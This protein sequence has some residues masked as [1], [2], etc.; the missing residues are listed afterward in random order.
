MGK[1]SFGTARV[2]SAVPTSKSRASSPSLEGD[3]E[4]KE[5]QGDEEQPGAFVSP[6]YT[7][8]DTGWGR[9]PRIGSRGQENAVMQGV[10][11]AEPVDQEA[12]AEQESRLRAYLAHDSDA[13]Q[14]QQVHLGRRGKQQRGSY[15]REGQNMAL[16]Q[17]S[18]YRTGSRCEPFLNEDAAASD[19]QAPRC[20]SK[21]T[22]G[23][24]HYNSVN[25][26]RSSDFI[27]SSKSRRP[28]VK[29]NR[30]VAELAVF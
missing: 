25:L 27:T 22:A 18:H 21:R 6:I 3:E 28:Q 7:D 14:Q 13:T 23:H 1:A 17:A 9:Q 12:L 24:V 26:A 15:P 2:Q 4:V 11:R 20:P 8:P 16:L 10:P 29:P 5:D 30:E 19:D